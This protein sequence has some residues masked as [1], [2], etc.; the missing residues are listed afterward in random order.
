MQ[1]ANLA[2]TQLSSPCPY[3]AFGTVIVNHTAVTPD[4]PHG[5]LI[6]QGVN[7]NFET[8]NPTLHGIP[9]IFPFTPCRLQA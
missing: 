5:K 7:R 2:L 8:G 4:S 9:A 1:Q 3:A 6:C